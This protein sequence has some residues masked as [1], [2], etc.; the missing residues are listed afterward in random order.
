MKNKG[1]KTAVRAASSLI[2]IPPYFEC[3]TAHNFI[4]RAIMLGF[5][6]TAGNEQKYLDVGV[7]SDWFQHS[8]LLKPVQT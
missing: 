1:S 3:T 2:E 5:A 4:A 7:S 6:N 8:S